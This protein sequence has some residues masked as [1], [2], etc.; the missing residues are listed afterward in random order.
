MTILN[1]KKT[2]DKRIANI[3]MTT[4]KYAHHGSGVYETIQG[5]KMHTI[6]QTLVRLCSHSIGSCHQSAT[7]FFWYHSDVQAKNNANYSILTIL[8]RFPHFSYC[9]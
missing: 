6:L 9:I 3:E 5:M 4:R 2:Q 1:R 7:K 8:T